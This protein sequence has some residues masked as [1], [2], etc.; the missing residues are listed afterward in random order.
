MIGSRTNTEP[1]DY[2][3][4]K[5]R[6]KLQTKLSQ[7]ERKQVVHDFT[8]KTPDFKEKT[9]EQKFHYANMTKYNHGKI[10]LDLV[11]VYAET[12][13]SVKRIKP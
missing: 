11:W 8:W 5:L 2:V 1:A 6:W 3:K 4:L 10:K 9:T 12:T 7:T 13:I